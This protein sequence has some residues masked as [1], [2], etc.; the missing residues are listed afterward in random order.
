MDDSSVVLVRECDAE[1][2][3]ERSRC[4]G[5]GRA[6]HLDL[7]A[8]GLDR[9]TTVGGSERPNWF[10]G[11]QNALS[12]SAVGLNLGDPFGDDRRV[13]SRLKRAAVL[14]EFLVALFH[15]RRRCFVGT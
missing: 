6:E 9:L 10:L 8:D 7:V 12:G 3:I 14:G 1:V 13:R 5:L 2:G 11:S 4:F 15:P